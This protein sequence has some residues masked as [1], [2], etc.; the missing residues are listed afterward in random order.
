MTVTKHKTMDT[1]KKI[2][3][4]SLVASLA[5]FTAGCKK[6]PNEAPEPDKEFQSTVDV[7]F[8]KMVITDIDMVCS[9]VGENDL[10]P[11]FYLAEPNSI[12]TVTVNRSLVNDYLFVS[13]NNTRCVDGRVR[14]GTIAMSYDNINPN[15]RYYRDYQFEGK[16]SLFNYKV[17]GW[18]VTLNNTFFVTS[19]LPS[20][21][22]DPKSTKLSW[23]LNGDFSFT[24]P[25]DASKNMR[26]NVDFVKTLANSTD[27][28]VF[29]AGKQS[30]ITWSLATVEYRGSMFG[31]TSGS[32]PFTYQIEDKN[33][34]VR[35]FSCYPDKIAGLGAPPT[36]KS[37]NSEFHPFAKGQAS[38]KTGDLYPRLIAYGN[39][40]GEYGD[41][42][43]D[44]KDLTYQCDNKGVVT[45][46]GISY[47]VDFTA[48]YK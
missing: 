29:N 15:A 14:N 9:F 7:H 47:P 24:N 18:D 46:K 32:V 5:F 4:A 30:A 11:K 22:Y 23:R 10:N 48:A 38:F 17:D 8:A 13:F 26:C 44:P 1:T 42:A 41:L 20:P 3:S 37:W 39:E 31:T 2:L 35:E 40:Q 33:P 21:G 36:F 45:I 28:A 27:P 6:T 19:L 12:N 34:L 43:K 25:A 16:I